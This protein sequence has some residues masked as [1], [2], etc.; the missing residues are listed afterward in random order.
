SLRIIKRRRIIQN[1]RKQNKQLTEVN[2]CLE[3]KLR[4]LQQK[5]RIYAT[6]ISELD[7]DRQKRFNKISDSA[8]L[9]YE[10]LKREDVLDLF[11]KSRFVKDI[12]LITDQLLVNT[13]NPTNR[14]N[15]SLQNILDDVLGFCFWDIL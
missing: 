5:Q 10:S 6:L 7:D 4:A 9:L 3:E 14:I 15:E 1:Q 11:V 12:C 8:N 2:I 13:L